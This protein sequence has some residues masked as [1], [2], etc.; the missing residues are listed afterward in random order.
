VLGTTVVLQHLGVWGVLMFISPKGLFVRGFGVAWTHRL[1]V[2]GIWSIWLTRWGV[3]GGVVSDVAQIG[4]WV[5]SEACL[6]VH[7]LSAYRP[8]LRY[9]GACATPDYH[10]QLSCVTP[11]ICLYLS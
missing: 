7:T 5:A 11:S 2:S 9:R 6:E 3:G 1:G 8:T 4:V 10:V